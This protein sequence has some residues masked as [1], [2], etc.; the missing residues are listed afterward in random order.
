MLDIV[1]TNGE[2]QDRLFIKIL[3]FFFLICY[4]KFYKLS[5]FLFEILPYTVKFFEKVYV[6]KEGV[7]PMGTY[8]VRL[9]SKKS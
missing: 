2:A 7:L 6:G 3:Q 9:F 4:F 1:A 5:V 8:F